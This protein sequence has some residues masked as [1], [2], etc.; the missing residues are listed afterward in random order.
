MRVTLTL[1]PRAVSS[2]MA[3][4]PST[5]AGTLIMTLGRLTVSHSIRPCSIVPWVSWASAGST[6]IET[7]PSRPPEVLKRGRKM[8]QPRATSCVV[9]STT[10]SLTLLPAEARA[11]TCSS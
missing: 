7:R 5:V 11:A 1:M 9:M 8:S 3:S 2:V 4:R 10:A 6:S